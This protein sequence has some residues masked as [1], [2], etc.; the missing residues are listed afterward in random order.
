MK[1]D[2]DHVSNCCARCRRA[3]RKAPVLVVNLTRRKHPDYYWGKVVQ[4]QD[5]HAA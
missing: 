1:P 5:T 2:P 4:L 3:F